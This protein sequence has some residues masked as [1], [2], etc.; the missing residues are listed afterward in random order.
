LVKNFHELPLFSILV[1]SRVPPSADLLGKVFLDDAWGWEDY[2]IRVHLG[3]DNRWQLKVF[4]RGVKF[5]LLRLILRRLLLG[6]P[7]Q[8]IEGQHSNLLLM[9]EC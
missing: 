1:I 9:L 7:L 5:V 6:L 3:H 4:V 8:M 2:L